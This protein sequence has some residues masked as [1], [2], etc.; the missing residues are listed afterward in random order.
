MTVKYQDTAPERQVVIDLEAIFDQIDQGL[1]AVAASVGLEVMRQMMQDDVAELVGPK[2][3]HNPV[4]QAI[5]HGSEKGS[6][7]LGG[8]RVAVDRPRVRTTDGVSEL[9]I[10]SYQLFNNQDVLNQSVLG[11]M[12][13]GVSTRDY[14][15]TLEPVGTRPTTR[16]TSKSAVSRR[17]VALTQD[18]LGKLMGRSLAG[19][20]LPVI[21]IDGIRFGDHLCLV[22]LGIDCDGVKHPLSIWRGASENK[23]VVMNLLTD[24]RERGLDTARPVL[25]VVDGGK[26]L[27]AGVREVFNQVM[28]QR[29]QV[30]KI[31]NVTDHLPK[32]MRPGVAKRMRDAY[33]L[34]SVIEAETVLEDLAKQLDQTHLAASGSLREGLAETLVVV[35]LQVHRLLRRTLAST[36]PIEA[37]NS[38]ARRTCKQVKRW[39]DGPM[40]ERWLAAALIDA[41]PR[42]HKI[43]GHNHLH[44]L[45]A[46]ITRYL[47]GK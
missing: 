30:H 19:L 12:L 23:T 4:R 27:T 31:R 21:M 8:R 47:T 9:A 41:E 5:R 28:I 39:R 13:A 24:L 37:L 16:S 45:P 29:C 11:R 10:N 18:A 2:G 36:N 17:L 34:D 7:I 33:Q 26:A 43:K 6:V 42:F 35:E 40:V 22:A 44:A 46:A 20:V 14:Q 15:K 32:K 1:M 3:R 25:V 38:M